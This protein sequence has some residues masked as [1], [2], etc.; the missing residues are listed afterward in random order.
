MLPETLSKS[1]SRNDGKPEHARLLLVDDEPAIIRSLERRL[2]REPY[3]VRTATCGEEAIDVLESW[4]ADIVLTDQRMPGMLGA[5]LL[6]I[7]SERWPD[8]VRIVLSG[9]A[10]ASAMLAAINRGQIY[11]YII[12]PWNDD[13][14]IV[15]LS[16]S[17][18]ALRLRRENERMS[19][20]LQEQN[21][22]LARH[23]LQ[24][25]Q[26]KRD[27]SIGLDFSQWLMESLSAGVV[28]L[29]PCGMIVYINGSAAEWFSGV[30]PD[31][32]GLPIAQTLGVNFASALERGDREGSLM[33]GS[34]ELVWRSNRVMTGGAER[35]FV[36]T[37]WSRSQREAA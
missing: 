14:L 1:E 11:K 17:V 9:Y 33:I 35:G 34:R 5:D 12:K 32:V 25:T 27:A 8:T 15:H 4:R 30:T 2:R 10:E 24:L 31:L 28:C 13:E 36:L 21:V 3:E 26:D 6:A 22:Q 18:E 29:D 16:R 37:F 19:L 20:T 23:N 7:V